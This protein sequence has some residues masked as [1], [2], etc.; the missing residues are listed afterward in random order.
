MNYSHYSKFPLR[1]NMVYVV[2]FGQKRA[3]IRNI[4][5]LTT[6]I[7]QGRMYWTDWGR[8]PM[9]ESSKMNGE[10]RKAII[11]DNIAWPNG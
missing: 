6:S 3:S 5:Y 9:I 11:T 4:C 8:N 2:Y 10:D 7:L 1:L